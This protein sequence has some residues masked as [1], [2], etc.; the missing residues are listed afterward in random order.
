MAGARRNGHRVAGTHLLDFLADA[1]APSP[2][3]DEIDL[4]GFDVMVRRRG[5]ADGRRASAS[6]W[7]RMQELRWA[8]NSRISDPSFVMNDAT[9]SR[10]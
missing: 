3:E 2:F 8:S 10:F 5:A 1:H 6:V 4:L 7:F 9:R